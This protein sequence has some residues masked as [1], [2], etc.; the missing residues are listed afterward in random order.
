ML[1]VITQIL[2]EMQ[3][4]YTQIYFP[5]QNQKVQMSERF[6]IPHGNRGQIH[7]STDSCVLS[8][9]WH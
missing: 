7:V 1:M 2:I 8:L 3:F 4:P 5:L 6:V 9:E